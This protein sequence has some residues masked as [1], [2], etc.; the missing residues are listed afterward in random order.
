MIRVLALAALLVAT[1]AAC[2]DRSESG[3][4]EPAAPIALS[5]AGANAQVA[6]NFGRSIAADDG[7]TVHAVWFEDEGAPGT[8][9]H[10]RST[11]GGE[12]WEDPRLVADVF[13]PQG[14]AVVA[15]SGANVYVAWHDFTRGNGDVFLQRSTDRGESWGP[16]R[17]IVS[18]DAPSAFPSIAAFDDH[19]QVVWGDNRHDGYAE[20]YTMASHDA[21]ETWAHPQRL[22]ETPF[23][24]WVPTVA[25]NDAVTVVAWIDYQDA[26]EEL[27]LRRSLDRGETW[28]PAQRLTDDPADTWAPS[29]AMD[30]ETVHIAWFDRRHA[31]SD[32]R[33]IEAAL[34]AAL[35]LVGSTPEPV[36]ARDPATYYLPLFEERREAKLATIEEAAAA[37]A[38]RGGDPDE[39]ESLLREFE[40][41]VREW[42]GGWEIYYRRS[43]DGGASFG[44]E[45]RL[46]EVA[47]KSLR[48]SIVAGGAFVAVAWLDERDEQMDVFLRRS[49][50][51]GLT[52]EREERL[53]DS[54]AESMR[55][56]AALGDGTIHVL[57]SEGTEADRRTTHLA[58]GR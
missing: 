40:A 25:V 47:G 27:Y 19:V 16:A 56:G 41:R 57:W 24:S 14:T 35:E 8:V 3:G 32:E 1:A 23:E 50:D 45:V 54:A 17:A 30:G 37:W 58:I 48:P 11:D 28:E 34:D 22:S 15:A 21:G 2:G 49:L 36:P 46:T 55:P 10:G 39:L 51:G 31:T 7:G 42:D 26:N 13:Q 33:D 5:P 12:T 44:P 43:E 6:I 4:A 29:L 53:T 9:W 18:G 38:E 52:W 20:V